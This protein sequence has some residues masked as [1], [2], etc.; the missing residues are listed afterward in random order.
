MW[1]EV[2]MLLFHHLP[3]PHTFTSYK[4]SSSLQ[5]F[6]VAACHPGYVLEGEYCVCNHSHTDIFRCDESNRYIYIRVCQKQQPL[7]T[8]MY[9]YVYIY[10]F[11][12]VYTSNV[13][14]EINCTQINICTTTII[15]AL[16]SILYTFL[17]AD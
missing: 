15:P 13:I 5:E 10:V 16:F 4:D 17:S 3:P 11:M 14:V 2:D 8:R 12:Y 6:T 1:W 7:Y 9:I